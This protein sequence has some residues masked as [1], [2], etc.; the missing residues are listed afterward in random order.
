MSSDAIYV[1]GSKKHALEQFCRTIQTSMPRKIVLDCGHKPLDGQS[2]A[3]SEAL[4]KMP[5]LEFLRIE[6]THIS[7]SFL[8]RIFGSCGPETLELANVDL[9]TFALE[10]VPAIVEQCRSPLSRIRDLTIADSAFSEDTSSQAPLGRPT[11]ARQRTSTRAFFPAILAHCCRLRNLCIVR[12]PLDADALGAIVDAVQGKSPSLRLL[13]LDATG[14][15]KEACADLQR[16]CKAQPKLQLTIHDPNG[17]LKA[18]TIK[19]SHRA[20]H[21]K[22]DGRA[23]YT[24]V[25]SIVRSPEEPRVA[26]A[27]P[28]LVDLALTAL[29]AG[30]LFIGGQSKTTEA[31]NLKSRFCRLADLPELQ[32]L[33][34]PTSTSEDN[35]S[36]RQQCMMEVVPFGDKQPQEMSAALVETVC[37]NVHRLVQRLSPLL[38]HEHATDSFTYVPIVK[39]RLDMLK[40]SEQRVK[41]RFNAVNRYVFAFAGERGTGKTQTLNAVIRRLAPPDSVFNKYS[42][43]PFEDGMKV[44][45]SPKDGQYIFSSNERAGVLRCSQVCSTEKEQADVDKRCLIG[46]EGIFRVRIPCKVGP[47]QPKGVWLEDSRGRLVRLISS[48][49]SSDDSSSSSEDE[50]GSD[51]EEGLYLAALDKSVESSPPSALLIQW[52]STQQTYVLA[53]PV[54]Q[55]GQGHGHVHGGDVHGEGCPEVY[56]AIDPD[57]RALCMLS[58]RHDATALRVAILTEELHEH[59]SSDVVD[60]NAAV[61][62]RGP[63]YLDFID[64]EDVRSEQAEWSS[65]PADVFGTYSHAHTHNSAATVDLLP[66]SPRNTTSIPTEIRFGDDVSIEVDYAAGPEVAA[67][68]S[69]AASRMTAL[70]QKKTKF[71]EAASAEAA[72]GMGEKAMVGRAVAMTGLEECNFDEFCRRHANDKRPV[73]RIFSLPKRYQ[74][75][76]GRTRRIRVR[77]T[78]ANLSLAFTRALL[79][80]LAGGEWSRV[81]CIKGALRVFVPW[82]PLHWTL[83]EV[84]A[85]I[86]GNDTD[87]SMRA[88]QRELSA[89]ALQNG[90]DTLVRVVQKHGEDDGGFG[91]EKQ[92]DVLSMAI[93]GLGMGEKGAMTAERGA[94]KALVLLLNH[95]DTDSSS[96]LNK[97]GPSPAQESIIDEYRV[98]LRHTLEQQGM[99]ME[100][101][102]SIDWHVGIVTRHGQEVTAVMDEL[103][104]AYDSC[105]KQK[106]LVQFLRF[107]LTEGLVVPAMLASTELVWFDNVLHRLRYDEQLEL[108]QY[109]NSHCRLETRHMQAIEEDMRTA[110]RHFEGA[111]AIRDRLRHILSP[112]VAQC[113]PDRFIKLLRNSS[114]D[115]LGQAA[116]MYTSTEPR[117]YDRIYDDL[118]SAGNLGPSPSAPHHQLCVLLVAP[119]LCPD[120]V[121]S[122]VTSAAFPSDPA[123]PD[124]FSSFLNNIAYEHAWSHV[125]R[126]FQAPTDTATN[127]LAEP[128]ALSSTSTNAS[129]CSDQGYD[130]CGVGRGHI[131]STS[132]GDSSSA[133]YTSSSRRQSIGDLVKNILT[134]EEILFRHQLWNGCVKTHVAVCELEVREWLIRHIPSCIAEAMK[135]LSVDLRKF[136]KKAQT[137]EERAVER[138]RELDFLASS[139]QPL[140]ADIL[141]RILDTIHT[142]VMVWDVWFFERDVTLLLECLRKRF[143]NY[144]EGAL[145]A[146]QQGQAFEMCRDFL[147]AVCPLAGRLIRYLDRPQ[148]KTWVG[149]PSSAEAAAQLARAMAIIESEGEQSAE[150]LAQERRRLQIRAD[151]ML[152]NLRK[153]RGRKLCVACAEMKAQFCNECLPKRFITSFEVFHCAECG[154]DFCLECFQRTALRHADHEVHVR[155]C[156]PAEAQPK[157]SK[158][159]LRKLS[160]IPSPSSSTPS[161]LVS[162]PLAA[163][164]RESARKQLWGATEADGKRLVG[165]KRKGNDISFSSSS[166]SSSSLQRAGTGKRAVRSKS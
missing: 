38:T 21:K 32:D 140:A 137:D 68:L 14:I 130:S 112:L 66:S 41:A 36:D 17:E 135:K 119:L 69:T 39:K 88:Y 150:S 102:G 106:Q 89:G 77:S 129:R 81:G 157:P 25:V 42:T 146:L 9:V 152:A 132:T 64:P 2:E 164:P 30:D 23:C 74:Q 11:R 53:C 1:D 8:F 93:K 138:R 134:H 59:Q 85:P 115:A 166:S 75:F 153:K 83:M 63:S 22:A 55:Q 29:P 127:N 144:N 107:D 28:A 10:D 95:T 78:S 94:H 103:Q 13:L 98:R 143:C 114:D 5:D 62:T 6:Q 155:M 50:S 43:L 46:G 72:G 71:K 26:P 118:R 61:I 163:T 19:Q 84:P 27:S 117:F 101:K 96:E 20:S 154:F 123:I 120:T 49:G 31:S 18:L 45:L 147:H 149:G 47:V 104:R 48:E 90:W 44:L 126:I 60:Y 4:K 142:N 148:C 133:S 156:I 24:E 87:G 122:L 12:T 73:R 145:G 92:D 165:Q 158:K 108:F 111:Q 56:A 121:S 139:C 136:R 57:N 159:Q 141:D 91:L 67:C 113:S 52:D 110:Y 51:E 37:A 82:V 116:Q 124:T 105:D 15:S 100:G 97:S 128:V 16:V 99:R 40:E 54:L 160:I 58:D 34:L 79:W 35:K 161:T 86:H 65:W 162:S 151:K 76:L 109:I 3:I 80:G 33:F 70:Q 131:W 7:A 125:E